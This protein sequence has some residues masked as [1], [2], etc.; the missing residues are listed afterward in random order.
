MSMQPMTAADV[1]VYVLR[2]YPG[3]LESPAFQACRA[4]DSTLF[5][6]VEHAEACLRTCDGWE[7]ETLSHNIESGFPELDVEQCDDIARAVLTKATATT[8]RSAS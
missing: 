1:L 3:A 4:H 2:K 6:A 5:D 7:V 8:E